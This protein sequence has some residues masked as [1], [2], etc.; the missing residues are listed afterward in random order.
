MNLKERSSLTK[1]GFYRIDKNLQDGKRIKRKINK[2]N[3]GS[4]YVITIPPI[5]I[6]Y[7]NSLDVEID[8]SFLGNGKIK[9]ITI[10]PI[11]NK[12]EKEE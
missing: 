12:K 9:E 7:I 11:D 1:G 6:D 2:M 4:K 5:I 8:V 3:N 10:Y